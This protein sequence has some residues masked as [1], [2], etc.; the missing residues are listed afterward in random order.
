METRFF[1]RRDVPG[2]RL[3]FERDSNG[4]PLS[5]VEEKYAYAL[6]ALLNGRAHS[7]G[8]SV[9]KVSIPPK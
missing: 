8:F 1:V 6:I 4:N 3:D 7:P 5:F 2:R 9:V